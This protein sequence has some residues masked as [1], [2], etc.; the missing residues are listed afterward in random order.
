MKVAFQAGALQVWLDEAGLSFD[1]VDGASGGVFNLA[2]LC[3][4]QS[5]TQ[6][7]DN[8]RGLPAL[9]AVQLNWRALRHPLTP[10]SLARLDRM[11]TRVF[12]RWG[13]DFDA[14]RASPL[15]A[16]F[17]AYNFT[18]HELEVLTP[19]Q[20]TEELLLSCV[21]L[22]MWFPPVRVDGQTY[23]DAVYV[24]DANVEEALRRG[25]DEIW[26]I[27]TVSERAQWG[28]GFLG[29]YFGIIETA[30]NAHF[31][32]ILQ[33]IETSNAA[34]ARGEHGEFGRHVEVKVLRGEVPLNYL[35][36]ANG[37]RFTQAVER[38]VEA[39]RRWCREEG[40]DF[41][42]R[43]APRAA[44]PVSL[45]FAD[46]LA[47]ELGKAPVGVRLG[48]EVDDVDAF[49]ARPEHEARLTGS[50]DSE[51]LG[52]SRHVDR[53]VLNLFADDGDP[54]VKEVRYRLM[55]HDADGRPRTL[56]GV[57]RLDGGAGRGP[58]KGLTTLQLRLLDGH[59][60]AGDEGHE[61][62]AGEARTAPRALLRR[63]AA[64]QVDAPT[65]ALRRSARRR[66]GALLIG[67]LWDVY[68]RRLLPVSPI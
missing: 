67:S 38:G 53:G 55:L 43:P 52:G 15:E 51:L 30:A 17:N 36:N 3:Q 61:L 37:D 62:A 9:D 45:R 11:R 25:A 32:R 34:I 2:M 68:A 18:R 33:R 46:A 12:A 31:R 8:W 63:L 24:T 20:M 5:G 10:E 56:V 6:A 22:P 28:D 23:I 64:M 57:K 4:G 16:T 19:D 41:T 65:P 47:G 50:V 42:P 60:E 66:V 26:V 13:L 48:V 29:N 1:H 54:S 21:S 59:V 14:I 27:W 35:L 7:A 49:I 39:A 58:A 40:I 44:E